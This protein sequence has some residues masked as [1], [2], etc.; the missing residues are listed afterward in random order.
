MLVINFMKLRIIVTL[1]IYVFLEVLCYR[2][3]VFDNVVLLEF[4]FE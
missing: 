3:C 4:L 1:E 2:K